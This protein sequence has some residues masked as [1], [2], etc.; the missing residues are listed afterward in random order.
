[1]NKNL[2][3][4]NQDFSFLGKSSSFQGL[5]KLQGPSFISGKFEGQVMMEDESSLTI[6]REGSF[7][8]E[9]KGT[10]LHIYGQFVGEIEASQTVTIHTNAD[11]EG[12]I[13]AK[14]LIVHP[15][16]KANLDIQTNG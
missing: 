3:L 16:A 14:N 5:W 2:H 13:Q 7:K 11:V 12:K 15:G 9:F 8:G 4:E 6:E 10:E 1:M